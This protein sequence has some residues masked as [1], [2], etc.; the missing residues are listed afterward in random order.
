MHDRTVLPEN[1]GYDQRCRIFNGAVT[2]RPA[3]FV[4]CE[5]REDVKLAVRVAR[6]MEC[7]FPCVQADM[8]G[9]AGRC[10]TTD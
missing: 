5:S 2:S 9:Q 8:T 6:N 1:E 4:L 3:L 10:G 7:R